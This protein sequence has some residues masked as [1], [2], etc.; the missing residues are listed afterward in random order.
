MKGQKFGGRKRGTQNRITSD[1]K[2]ILSEA[3][4]EHLQS[5]LNALPALKRAELLVKIL[6]FVLPPAS[7]ADAMPYIEPLVIIRTPERDTG[8]H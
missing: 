8:P 4:H 1:L 7:D 2:Q 5:D 3:V 6:P